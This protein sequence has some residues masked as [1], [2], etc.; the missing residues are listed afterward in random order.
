MTATVRQSAADLLAGLRP[1]VATA[2][3]A[4]RNAVKEHPALPAATGDLI[5]LATFAVS[6]NE[7]GFKVHARRMLREGA[8]I[9]A[10]RQ[11]VI[12]PLG[13]ATSFAQTTEALRW[14]DAAADAAG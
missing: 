6:G 11:A 4:L 9:E 5:V 1:D 8:D 7:T 3:R 12:V 13:H 2:F 14:I 10:L